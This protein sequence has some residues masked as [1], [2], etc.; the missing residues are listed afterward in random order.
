MKILTLR[1]ENLNALKG[2][3]FIDFTQA[4]FDQD[5][6]FAIT[7]P[8]GAG[9]TT[10]LDAICLALYQQ[11]P[12]QKVSKSQNQIMTRHTASCL[13]EVE[14]EVKGKGY[15]A[16]WS[17]R[18]AKNN[19]E[20]NL[21]DAKAELATHDGE[22]LA[23]KPSVVKSKIEL[24]S[25]LDFARFTKSMMLSQGQFAAFLNAN[26]NQRAELLEE[27]T[28][29]EIYG[30]IS[31][32]V[33]ENYKQEDKALALIESQ[34]SGLS[35]LNDEE[36]KNIDQ[37][38]HVAKKQEAELSKS[39]VS[40]TKDKQ[41]L[42]KK[43]ELTQ[44]LNQQT[45]VLNETK[46]SLDG[47]KAQ[48]DLLA[49]A[50]PAL[51]IKG[52]Y[53]Q[54]VD[55]RKQCLLLQETVK[56]LSQQQT[57]LASVFSKAQQEVAIANDSAE[58]ALKG[59]EQQE[60]LFIEQVLPLEHE[61]KQLGTLIEQTTAKQKKVE[62]QLSAELTSQ[63]QTTLQLVA[64]QKR[65]D[66][67]QTFTAQ[68]GYV[69][70]LQE[71]L[72]VWQQ[73]YKQVQDLIANRKQLDSQVQTLISQTSQ[74]QKRDDEL[75]AA[76]QETHRQ[77]TRLDEQITNVEQEASACLAQHQSDSLDA[78]YQQFQQRSDWQTNIQ[79]AKQLCEQVNKITNAQAQLRND[80][81]QHQTRL[82]ELTQQRLA[83]RGQYKLANTQVK[84]LQVIVE[85]QRAIQALSD[86]R[87]Q[88]NADDP[89]PLCGST[90]HPAIEEYRD[91]EE[92]EYQAR[93][94]SAQQ[95]LKQIEEYGQALSQQIA[96]IEQTIQSIST[97]LEGY[98][99]DLK[100]LHEQWAPIATK[101]AMQESLQV[102]A[103]M[104][105]LLSA[106]ESEANTR[107]VTYEQLQALE[108][109]KQQLAQHQHQQS[110]TL[111]GIESERKLVKQTVESMQGQITQLQQQITDLTSQHEQSITSLFNAINSLSSDLLNSSHS[112]EQAIA[113]F[114]LQAKDK[115]ASFNQ[116]AT[117]YE[118]AK[119]SLENL[120]QQQALIAQK[121]EQLSE[122]KS[123]LQAELATHS[124]AHAV[125]T[126]ERLN[127]V[128]DKRVAELR[129]EIAL[130][131]QELTVKLAELTNQ[132]DDVAKKINNIDGEC[133]A[134]QQQLSERQ[135]NHQQLATKWQ[136]AMN[137]CGFENEQVFLQAL[138]PREQAEQIAEQR[139]L[140]DEEITKLTTNVELYTHQL[141]EV[142][143]QQLT[144]EALEDVVLKFDTVTQSLKTLQ[145]TL[146]QNQ[147]Q[148]AQHQTQLEKQSALVAKIQQQQVVVDDLAKL[149]HLIGS[150]DG[151]KYRRFAQSLTLE[152]L[153]YLANRRLVSLD[154][155]YQLQRKESDAL[156]LEVIDTWQ[157]DSV[158]DTSTLSGG[159][160]F[161]V[162]LALALALSD[163]VSNK[164]SIDSLFL[165]EGFGTLDN[166]TL[167]LALNALDSLNASGKM[168][169]I[170]SHVDA[171][172]ERVN[173]QIKVT[174][175]SGLGVSQ[176]APMFKFNEQK[177]S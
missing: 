116:L 5:A 46:Q 135:E 118:Q 141:E 4:P 144:T 92:D 52:Q 138:V 155:R 143:Y 79:V 24:L 69:H 70:Q 177:V 160:S 126:S 108:K 154:G 90:E 101:F 31:Q 109:H 16:F 68:H 113:Q 6:L 34:K 30:Q 11:T 147:Q 103:T 95:D 102:L 25:G 9:K 56:K 10:I 124:Q 128:G 21:V 115:L 131:K 1:F 110:L 47:H 97:T 119:S 64:L 27:L 125:K 78:F 164:T 169:G 166:E 60:Q 85:Q 114:F 42:L 53:D 8:T 136:D 120:N 140:A 134:S 65:Q 82:E 87:N 32:Q 139:R 51:K 74:N 20:G 93:L 45:Q 57:D 71:N 80:K 105:D 175:S 130:K 67:Y 168:I 142:E 137:T 167:E 26:A 59:F 23:E 176:L 148:L 89:C 104:P 100:S 15:R 35:L 33:Y 158:R 39:L 151:A 165:D 73:N 38:L 91:I 66:D 161:L 122:Q 54:F 94:L 62:H 17:Q 61:I 149:N 170:I 49:K 83:C 28:G 43:S 152:H 22:I 48:F 63:Q 41:W 173:V 163:L 75:T 37:S 40:L 13:A 153:V 58:M 3:W 2:H 172:K 88:L 132:R 150:A 86:Y 72:A 159:E 7:G 99:V 12:R 96:V 157:A 106:R 146:G 19:P 18:R 81:A 133:S 121:V 111:S 112:P 76:E 50:E 44:K 156:A 174:K 55:S 129:D 145:V 84:D 98:Q 171:L 117:A 162:S 127:L 107:Q 14:F 36:L 29:T 77:K 123:A